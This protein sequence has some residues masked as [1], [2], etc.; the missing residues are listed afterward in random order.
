MRTIKAL[1][2]FAMIITASISFA[3]TYDFI[4]LGISY[5]GRITDSEGQP[6]EDG[7]HPMRFYLYDS[8]EDGTLL[9]RQPGD[10]EPAQQVETDSGYFT[11]VL[12]TS[13]YDVFSEVINENP[14]DR[15]LQ[16]EVAGEF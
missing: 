5:Q 11:V 2:I 13:D 4:P 9:W 14:S 10:G 1:L 12:G 3:Q 8:D 7:T 15:W 16:I 6:A